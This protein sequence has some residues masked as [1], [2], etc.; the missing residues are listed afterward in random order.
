VIA[1]SLGKLTQKDGRALL[2]CK[3]RTS[4]ASRRLSLPGTFKDRLFGK[5]PSDPTW[6]EL[7]VQGQLIRRYP[8]HKGT[9]EIVQRLLEA[10]ELG[11]KQAAQRAQQTVQQAMQQV[12]SASNGMAKAAA[13][14]SM[15]AQLASLADPQ[16]APDGTPAAPPTPAPT[17]ATDPLG[18]LAPLVQMLPAVGVVPVAVGAFE[19]GDDATPGVDFPDDAGF[20]EEPAAAPT[21]PFLMLGDGSPGTPT[22]EAPV[23]LNQQ[24]VT[25][26]LDAF[27]AELN[28]LDAHFNTARAATGGRL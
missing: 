25:A 14:G 12:R 9:G 7:D 20:D 19:P 2:L 27:E 1:L 16:L 18:A 28:D 24:E 22:V 26:D 10:H 8:D 3:E 11:H 5:L 21:P 6:Y 4:K 13:I 17:F 15:Q 23:V